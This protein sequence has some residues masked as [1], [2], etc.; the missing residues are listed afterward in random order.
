[1]RILVTGGAGYIGS[2]MMRMFAAQNTSTVVVDTM[3]NGH[4]EALPDSTTL[5]EGSIGDR[6]I[7]KKVFSMGPFDGVL[8]FSGSISVEESVANPKKYLENNLLSPIILLEA[9]EEASVLFL[10]FSSTAAVYGNPTVVPI[11]EDHPKNP[12]SPYG[13]SKLCFEDVLALYGRKGTI[14]SISLRYFNASGASLDGA[15]GEAH[16]PE[17]HIIPNAMRVALGIN[18]EFLFFG[19]DY[20]TPDGTCIRDY[21]HVEDLCQAHILALDAL[22]GGHMGGAYN[23][24]TGNGISNREVIQAVKKISGVDFP[25]REMPKRPGDSDKLIA[26]PTKLMK[27]F[28]WKPKYSDLQTIVETAWKWHKSHPNGYMS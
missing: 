6:E 20:Q 8:H 5:V 2:H 12:T 7:I 10:I 3:A 24:G 28:G 15:H 16:T 18:K 14:R 21:I 27:E 19:T 1:M 22:I 11:P 25:V 17:Q 4:K 26:D 13:L 9:M 23:V